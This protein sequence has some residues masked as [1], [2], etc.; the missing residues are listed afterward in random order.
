VEPSD[1]ALVSWAI[2]GDDDALSTLL[3]RHGAS[4]RAQ[5]SSLIGDKW[6]SI[7]D[8]DDVLQ[9]SYLEAFLRI[10]TFQN[11]GEGSFLAWLKRIATNNLHDAIEQLSRLK[12]PQ[13]EDRIVPSGDNSAV[14]LLERLGCTST[15]PSRHA[16]RREVAQ[17]V[18]SAISRLPDDYAK[19]VKLYDLEG[20]A[21]SDVAASLGRTVGA[22]Y[23]LRARAHDRLRE[24]FGSISQV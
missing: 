2:D 7:I 11:R 16:G 4:L 5:I 19:V 10:A 9:V 12:R 3:Q 20:Q 22:V 13:P 15:T 1:E 24:A 18:E 8:A 23:M 6:Q 21:V 14:A 17:A